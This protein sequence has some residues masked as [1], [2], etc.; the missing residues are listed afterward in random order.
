VAKDDIAPTRAC[1]KCG[2]E[3]L[4]TTEFFPPQKLGK[5]G[6][7]SSCRP[8]RAAAT[9]SWRANGP[10]A[11][12][13]VFAD[14]DNERVCSDCGGTFPATTDHFHKAQTGKGG[15]NRRCIQCR[16]SQLSAY[17]RANPERAY[18]WYY[19]NHER[20]LEKRRAIWKDPD[21]AAKASAG[22]KRWQQNNPEA[23]RLICRARDQ[24]RRALEKGAQ[25]SFKSS[26]I[27]KLLAAQ[28]GKCWWCQSKLAKYHIDHRVPLAKGGTNYPANLVLSCAPCNQRKSAKLPWEMESPRLL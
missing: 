23:Y 6:V 10:K 27:K 17:K 20:E 18:A 9:A 8:C 12:R 5:F 26:D 7:A 19:N 22:V 21:K 25:G 28:K 13:A 15:L 11:K 2:I 16:N 4:A 14:S 3:K 24:R 1:T